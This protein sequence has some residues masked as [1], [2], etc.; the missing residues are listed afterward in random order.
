[1]G[2]FIYYVKLGSQL[3][4]NHVLILFF[5]YIEISSQLILNNT[6]SRI[7]DFEINCEPPPPPPPTFIYYVEVGSQLIARH[8]LILFFFFFFFFYIEIS[9]Q[10]ILNNTP[11]RIGDF[12]IN[13]EPPPPPLTFICDVEV[14]SQLIARLRIHLFSLAL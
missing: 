7:G 9:S 1:M 12:E 6:T 14:G 3:F 5:F 8:V 2:T 10:L 13:R 11:S 4:V